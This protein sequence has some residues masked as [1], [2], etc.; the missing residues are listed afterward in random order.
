MGEHGIYVSNFISMDMVLVLGM[1]KGKNKAW[2]PIRIPKRQCV[3]IW[4]Q[5]VSNVELITS[6]LKNE[7][8]L[9]GEI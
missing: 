9:K 4:E 1:E 2:I 7:L 3:G 6:L 8:K 5:G